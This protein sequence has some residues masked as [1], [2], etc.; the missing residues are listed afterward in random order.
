MSRAAQSGWSG[1]RASFGSAPRPG[2]CEIGTPF[3]A[4]I[5]WV[6][7]VT[8]ADGTQAVLKIN[9]PEPES[10]HEADALAHWD[11]LGAVRLLEHDAAVARAA[12]RALRARHA[13]LGRLPTR[14]RRI[15]S[16]PPS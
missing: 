8:R 1:C 15:A 9:F 11:G 6:A 3:E 10:E 7:P 12:G 16:P 14:T 2:R 4:H 13:A 5:S